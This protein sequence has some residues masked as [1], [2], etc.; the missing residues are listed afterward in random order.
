MLHM[1]KGKE[2]TP[3]EL[4]KLIVGMRHAYAKGENAMAFARG[5][6]A[7]YSGGGKSAHCDTCCL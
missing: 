6:L 3:L 4:G 2:L 7:E 5:A 1:Q